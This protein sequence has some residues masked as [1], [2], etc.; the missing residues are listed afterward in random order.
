MFERIKTREDLYNFLQNIEER[1][2]RI[3][4]FKER[5]K[6]PD[7]NNKANP[8][9]LYGYCVGIGNEGGGILLVWVNDKGEIVGTTAELPTNI[10]KNIF[11]RTQQKIIIDQ[12]FLDNAK[13]VYIINIPSRRYWE[14]LR[15]NGIPLMRVGDS[16]IQMDDITMKTILNEGQ[17][18][19]RSKELCTE[20]SFDDLDPEAIKKAREVYKIKHPN[21]PLDER[22]DLIFLNKAKVTING[23]ITRTALLLLGKEESAHFLS[24]SNGSISRVLRNRDNQEIDYEHFYPPLL[25][26]LDKVYAKIRNLKYRYL[27]EWSLFPEEVVKFDP[28][29]IREAL[30]NCIAHQDYTLWGRILLVEKEDTLLFENMGDF[31]PKTI[32][33][34]IKD[35]A[36]ASQYRN[37]FLA[38]AML[39]LNMIDTIGSGIRK[40]FDIQY[41]KFFP[42]PDYDFSDMKVR[43][44]IIGKVLDINYARQ[45]AQFK[46]ISLLEIM[47]LDKIQKGKNL[48]KDEVKLL[49]DKWLIEG[50]L[51]NI[52][53]SAVL[54]KNTDQKELYF[55]QR[56]IDNEYCKK[57]IL[58]YLEKFW[59]AKKENFEKILL[60]KLSDT[61]TDKQKKLKITNILQAL[62]RENIIQ[63]RARIWTLVG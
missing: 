38:D 42:L 33:K 59:S 57:I 13:K 3:V 47:M 5:S 30:N 40:M 43:V 17:I 55:K 60:E 23:K 34:V 18:K 35:N 2:S 36:P 31:I 46:D 61:L 58:D 11:D 15:W 62:R 48:T 28:Y 56:W 19:D 29:I 41:K 22:D 45:L 24:P 53:I 63:V 21:S 9:N 12:I 39:N 10:E 7:I 26:S 4:E 1:E 16:L 25:L 51:P 20:A 6:F 32:E 54:A 44:T 14:L 27:T 52:H 8:R 49:R 50:K 37:R